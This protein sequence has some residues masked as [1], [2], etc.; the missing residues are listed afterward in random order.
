M[1]KNIRDTRPQYAARSLVSSIDVVRWLLEQSCKANEHLMSL[2]IAQGADFCRRTDAQWKNRSL[3]KEK[4]TG[5]RRKLLKVVLQKEEQTL[6]QLYGPTAAAGFDRESATPKTQYPRLKKVAA[7]LAE[8]KRAM[9][10]AAQGVKSSVF[11][12]VEQEE[13]KEREVEFE[14]EQVREKQ[15]PV[16]FRAC[17][18]PGLDSEIRKFVKTG[19]FK[20]S[21]HTHAFEYVGKTAIGAKYGVKRSLSRLFVS[22][23]F[24]RTVESDKSFTEGGITVSELYAN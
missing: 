20:S 8:K 4:D 15:K 22:R 7:T 17:V 6:E 18:F 1:Y 2:H 9:S 5:E 21:P 12:Q 24:E 14:V 10:T 16:H 13:E 23:Q 3:F 19:V 11:A